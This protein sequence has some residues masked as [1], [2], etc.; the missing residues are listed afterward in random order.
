VKLDTVRNI[1]VAPT[2]AELL[3]LTMSNI[4]GKSLL[5]SLSH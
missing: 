2:V 5:P 3:G 1:D 4:T